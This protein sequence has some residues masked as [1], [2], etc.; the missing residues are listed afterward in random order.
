M[1]R[2]LTRVLAAVSAVPATKVSKII[3][4]VHKKENFFGF[5]FEFC[6]VSLLVMLIYE[7]FV[8]KTIFD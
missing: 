2:H 6:I 7:G 5:D 8:K 1:E 4:K 3:L